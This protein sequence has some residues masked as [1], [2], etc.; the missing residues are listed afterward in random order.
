MADGGFAPPEIDRFTLADVNALYDWWAENPPLRVVVTGI[1]IALGM[2]PPQK[3]APS[4]VEPLSIAAIKAQYPD[5][6]I[7]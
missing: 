3:A 4:K 7:R 1:A 6:I 2:T 5:G